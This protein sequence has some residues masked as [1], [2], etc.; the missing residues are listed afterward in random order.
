MLVFC[1][2]LLNTFQ[3]G[4]AN[5]VQNIAL[6]KIIHMERVGTPIKLRCASLI[7]VY[8]IAYQRRS[9]AYGRSTKRSIK[10]AGVSP[11]AVL[12]FA[13]TQDGVG[14]CPSDKPRSL[15]E[16]KSD[17]V[18]TT[19]QT[20]LPPPPSLPSRRSTET[21]EDVQSSEKFTHSAELSAHTLYRMSLEEG[22]G[23]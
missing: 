21:G 19:A 6:L 23:F 16:A 5:I 20:H 1:K 18:G 13:T 10:F 2:A 3:S 11:T 14:C 22:Q 12:K 15:P 4:V 17:H 8:V 9:Y 7:V